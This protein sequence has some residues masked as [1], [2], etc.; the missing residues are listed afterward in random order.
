MRSVQVSGAP[1][2]RV[3]RTVA[4]G[5]RGATV[6]AA[7]SVSACECTE[8]YSPVAMDMAPAVRPAMPVYMML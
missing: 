3:W 4:A 2:A 6:I 8:T 1:A 7:C 5:K